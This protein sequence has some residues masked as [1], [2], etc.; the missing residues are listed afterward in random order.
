MR[1]IGYIILSMLA[2]VYTA[3]AQTVPK[4]P[5]GEQVLFADPFI[6][7]YDGLYYAYGTSSFDGIDD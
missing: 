5:E 2:G 3:K 4:A 7:Y 1:F 6:F